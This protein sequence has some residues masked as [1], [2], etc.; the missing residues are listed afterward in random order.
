MIKWP[1]ASKKTYAWVNDREKN[2][3]KCFESAANTQIS[4]RLAVASESRF[5]DAE[6]IEATA[7]INEILDKAR[8]SNPEM[9]LAFLETPRGFVL[10]W[11]G[12]AISNDAEVDEIFKFLKITSPIPEKSK[13]R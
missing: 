8:K 3:V 1:F 7:K 2:L 10:G 11:C 9:D 5:H 13:G 4:G 6:L 12:R